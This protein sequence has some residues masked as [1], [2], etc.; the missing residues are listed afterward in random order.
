MPRRRY[1]IMG[2]P[3]V[4]EQLLVDIKKGSSW[5]S[6]FSDFQYYYMLPSKFK[7]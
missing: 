7:L 6:L 4:G 2:S 3:Q 5:K 1:E